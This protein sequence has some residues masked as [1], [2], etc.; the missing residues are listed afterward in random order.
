M[1]HPRARTML[2]LSLP[3]VAIGIASSLILIVVMKIASALQNLLWQR[4]PGTLGIAQD[5]PLWIIG[6]LT[7]TGIAVGLV[8]RFSQGHAG[9]D[10]A[11]EPLIGAPVP[12]SA[13]PGLIVALILGLAGGVSLGP[14]HPIMTVNIALAVAIGARLLPRVNRMEWTILASAGTIGALFGT[15][16]A[17]ALIFSQTL[18]GS[19]EVPL[20]DRLFAPLMAAAAGAL[21]TGL[22]FHPH[23]SLPIAHYG[24]ME[25]TDILSGAIVAAIAIAAGM[26]AV[27]CLPRLHSMMH[28]MKNP[29]LVLGIGG[30]ILGILGVIG[31]PVSLF[32][33]LDEMQQ[34]VANQAFSTSDYF[35]LAVIKLA[36]LV[37]AAASGFRGGRIFPAVFVGVALGLM[38][39]EHVPAVPAAITVSCAILGIV[40]VVTRDGWLSLFMAAVVVPNTTLLPL[41]CIVMLPAW[42]L[43]AG[44]PMMMV[45]RPKQQP[46][47]DN[48]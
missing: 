41:L 2:L 15:P 23:F 22:F 40:L 35:L 33:G 34:M 29:V 1:L 31:G 43:L 36:A 3:A 32:K 37:V 42:L 7:L 26:V 30:F 16:V 47:H 8:I 45:N 39:H 19:S 46:P 44:K 4:L 20:W 14:E 21:T 13:L 9:P 17:A 10:P 5:S 27:W 24:Q 6:V 11:C 18:N 28:Q 48:V 25:M 38:L 12:P